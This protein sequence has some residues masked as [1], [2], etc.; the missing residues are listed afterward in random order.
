MEAAGGLTYK[1]AVAACHLAADA[2][3][4][5]DGG[6]YGLDDLVCFLCLSQNAEA[7]GGERMAEPPASAPGGHLCQTSE[8]P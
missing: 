3:W 5:S 2:L 8:W 1:D 6:V 7:V 4:G